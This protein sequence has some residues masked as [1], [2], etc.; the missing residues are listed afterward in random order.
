MPMFYGGKNP[1]GFALKMTHADDWEPVRYGDLPDWVK[2]DSKP[3]R[4]VRNTYKTVFYGDPYDYLVQ[5]TVEQG[6]LT[7]SYWKTPHTYQREKKPEKK[8]PGRLFGYC[9]A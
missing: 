9:M 5:Y 8:F 2:E 4:W 3:Q 1:A 6:T 7:L